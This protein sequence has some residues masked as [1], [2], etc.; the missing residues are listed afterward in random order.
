MVEIARVA[1][2]RNSTAGVTGFLYHDGE[3]FAQALEGLDPDVGPIY[4]SIQADPRHREVKTIIYE[5]VEI[6]QFGSWH[7]GFNEP[8]R[9]D[10][11]FEA[12]FGHDVYA[13]LGKSRASEL[14]RFLKGLSARG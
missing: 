3:Y 12:I 2:E 13:H 6:R 5:A 4:A 14:L 10:G 11:R 7:M 8:A 1:Q 9:G